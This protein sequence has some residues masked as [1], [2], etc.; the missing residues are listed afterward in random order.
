MTQARKLRL[1]S[2]I[3]LGISL[4]VVLSF[5]SLSLGASKVGLWEIIG[6]LV[7]ERTEGMRIILDIRLPRLLSAI[8]VGASLSAAGAVMQGLFRN[9]LV[10][11][12]IGGVASGAAFGAVVSIVFGLSLFSP[13]SAYGIPLSAFLGAI[14]ALSMTIL[15]SRLGGGSPLS[16]I[17][18]GIAVSF[19]F[20][21][22]TSLALVIGGEKSFGAFFWLFGSFVAASWRHLALTLPASIITLGYIL[23][24]ARKLNVVLLGD[25]EARQLGVNITLIRYS[26]LVSLSLLTALAVSFNGIIGFVG[27]VAPHI[28]RLIVGEDYRLLLPLSI[29]TGS[30]LLLAS[31]LA[32]RLILAPAELPVGAITSLT[33]APIFLHLL[34][35]RAGRYG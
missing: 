20:S 30:W 2:I 34:V 31:D 32:S 16:L 33:G 12:Y 19:L 17:L 8:V 5:A 22:A 11:P 6:I 23:V 10:D 7:G 24:H 13:F 14:T 27:L 21:A 9:P 25:E 28:A 29:L 1:L 3:F 15:F 26:M 35:K 4:T 18:S